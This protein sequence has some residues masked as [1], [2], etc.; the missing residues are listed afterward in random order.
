MAHTQFRFN[1]NNRSSVDLKDRYHMWSVNKTREHWLKIHV[2]SVHVSLRNTHA[3][4]MLLVVVIQKRKEPHRIQKRESRPFLSKREGRSQPTRVVQ[5][6][7]VVNH[8]AKIL[9]R[10]WDL[11]R[12]SPKRQDEVGN[13][14]PVRRTKH[15]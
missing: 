6:E 8:P 13:R 5:D 14:S 10:G 9:Q 1:F 11:S 12:I 2:D 15:C 3:T 7:Q 4:A